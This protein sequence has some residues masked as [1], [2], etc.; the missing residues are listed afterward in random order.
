MAYTSSTWVIHQD[1]DKASVTFEI[2]DFAAAAA[3]NKMGKPIV[4]KPFTIGTSRFTIRVYPSGENAD[5]ENQISVF[6]TNSDDHKVAVS[7]DIMVG[8]KKNSFASDREITGENSRG[9]RKFME[10]KD[11]GPNLTLV[12]DITLKKE[13]LTEV[14][15]GVV[16]KNYLK[17]MVADMKEDMKTEMKKEMNVQLTRVKTEMNAEI[18]KT[19]QPIKIPECPICQ[20]LKNF[21]SYLILGFWI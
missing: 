5:A 3:A 7:C 11:V 17:E 6:L 14:D 10:R 16:D 8:G 19:R 15:R 20:T 21:T 4:S 1:W 9:W 2:T 12:A 13:E 18:A